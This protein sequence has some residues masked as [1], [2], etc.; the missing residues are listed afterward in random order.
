[1]AKRSSDTDSDD[2]Y[3]LMTSPGLT[4][5]LST[6]TTQDVRLLKIKL[7]ASSPEKKEKSKVS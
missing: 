4:Q 7:P 3:E 5:S 2:E 1:M 6:A